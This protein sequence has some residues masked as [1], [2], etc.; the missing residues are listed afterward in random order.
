MGTTVREWTASPSTFGLRESGRP[1]VVRGASAFADVAL[2]RCAARQAAAAT[3]SNET[4]GFRCCRGTAP[5]ARYPVEPERA[6]FQEENLS[7][8]AIREVLAAVPE[9]ADFA[10][11]FRPFVPEQID[12]ALARRRMSRTSLPNWTFVSASILK[13]SPRFGEEAWIITGATEAAEIIA[14]VHPLPDGKFVHGTS[15]ILERETQPIAIAYSPLSQREL[16]WSAC[17]GCGGDGGAITF[18]DD[19]RIV[20]AQR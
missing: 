8:R 16:L 14:V 3:F 20:I 12:Q 4:L 17:W 9:L 7:A 1:A 5:S 19:A 10:P 2:H 18:R 13:W 6:M 11:Q 15:F